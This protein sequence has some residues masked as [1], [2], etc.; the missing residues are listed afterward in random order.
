MKSAKKSKKDRGSESRDDGFKKKTGGV[1]YDAIS[2][3]R[4]DDKRH[5]R[6][7]AYKEQLTAN[8]A[9]S[10]ESASGGA[11][12]TSSTFD[13]FQRMAAGKEGRTLAEK[14]AD[15]NRPTWEQYKKDNEDKLDN[16]GAE[17]RKMAEYRAQLDREREQ[18]LAQNAQ[19]AR[20][21]RMQYSDSEDEE[22]EGDEEEDSSS[23]EEDRRRKKDKKKKDKKSSGGKKEK[24][25]K[26]DKSRKKSKKK[27]RTH[28]SDS[29][30]AHSGSARS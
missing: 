9:K 4:V 16:I 26:K 23:E 13:A 14:I 28:S 11:G 25:S 2:D 22:E 19:N 15:P 6:E 29:D 27:K 18:L 7:K 20:K 24:K 1:N 3:K 21:R 10:T 12:S 17:V 30:S 5:E 8:S